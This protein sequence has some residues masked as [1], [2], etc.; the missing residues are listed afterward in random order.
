MKQK[1]IDR[2]LKKYKDIFKALE[3]YDK[4]PLEKQFEEGEKC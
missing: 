4:K 1:E 2:I 3:D